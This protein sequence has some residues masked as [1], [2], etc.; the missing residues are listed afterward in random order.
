[1]TQR[2]SAPDTIKD[3][4]CNAL[5]DSLLSCQTIEQKWIFYSRA[6]FMVCSAQSLLL[7][8]LMKLMIPI[9][10]LMSLCMVSTQASAQGA[11]I[12]VKLQGAAAK[13]VTNEENSNENIQNKIAFG[14]GFQAVLPL[15]ANVAFQPELMYVT[16]GYQFE[17]EALKA[18]TS[19]DL[20][21]IQAP[22]L[23]SLHI[24]IG[25][26]TPKVLVGPYIGYNLSASSTSTVEIN[27]KTNTTTREADD[28]DISSIDAGV[29]IAPGV[30]ISLGDFTLTADVRFERGLLTVINDTKDDDYVHNQ[31]ISANLGVLFGF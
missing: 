21:Y 19:L 7:E 12:G 3:N 28:D 1:M 15:A 23:F 6:P 2:L 17:I 30:N 8:Y 24:P 16:R 4:Y 29:V 20:G 27:G 13:L 9:V 11:Q 5:Y 25:F 18:E 14:L 22:L 26:I 10:T 31:A